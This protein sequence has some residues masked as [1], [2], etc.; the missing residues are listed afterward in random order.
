MSESSEKFVADRFKGLEKRL[1]A[2]DLEPGTFEYHYGYISGIMNSV[3]KLDIEFTPAYAHAKEAVK[4]VER[5]WNEV[6]KEKKPFYVISRCNL[7]KSKTGWIT[8]KKYAQRLF[9]KEAQ[10]QV[11]SAGSRGELWTITWYADE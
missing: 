11:R 7:F 5:V 6:Y 4:E 10:A 2:L 8:Q 9:Y 1:R 3:L